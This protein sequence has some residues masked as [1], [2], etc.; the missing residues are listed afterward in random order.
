MSV[1]RTSMGE[2]TEAR[3]IP[4]TDSL[5]PLSDADM[6]TIWNLAASLLGPRPRLRRDTAEHHAADEYE[7]LQ[8]GAEALAQATYLYTALWSNAGERGIMV[9]FNVIS[10]T[11]TRLRRDPMTGM[12][13]LG[14]FK[15]DS[16]GPR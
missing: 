15:S 1:T 6:A 7:L 13:S 11:E 3:A 8:A 4:R 16:M 2:P 12:W 10:G 14:S 9:S 5:G